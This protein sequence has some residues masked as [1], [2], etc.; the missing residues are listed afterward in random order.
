IADRVAAPALAVQ[1][2]ALERRVVK[3]RENGGQFASAQTATLPGRGVAQVL[4]EMRHCDLGSN[5]IAARL[6]GFARCPCNRAEQCGCHAQRT[7]PCR[8]HWVQDT[9]LQQEG[10]PWLASRYIRRST[11]D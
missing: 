10:S 2:A 8:G 3:D 7:L 5:L 11:V 1:V 6:D 4:L 9:R